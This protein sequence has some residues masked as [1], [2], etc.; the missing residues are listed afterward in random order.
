[1]AESGLRKGLKTWD[2]LGLKE[3]KQEESEDWYFLWQPSAPLR[4][5]DL[6]ED[7]FAHG[8]PCSQFLGI[9]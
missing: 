2:N 9:K 1:M 5:L 4:L 3:H 7:L 8:I 6:P